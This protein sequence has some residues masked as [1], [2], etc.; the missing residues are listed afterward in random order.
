MHLYGGGNAFPLWEVLIKSNHTFAYG[1][2]VYASAGYARNAVTGDKAVL[3]VCASRTAF[4]VAGLV[5]LRTSTT[6]G[7]GTA[8][9]QRPKILI[10]P[11]LDGYLF[12]GQCSGTTTASIGLPYHLVDIEGAAANSTGTSNQ[13]INE[14]ATSNKNVYVVGFKG[15][16]SAP[17]AYAEVLFSWAKTKFSARGNTAQSNTLIGS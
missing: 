12:T 10:W 3:G 17:G 11:A 2:A 6:A 15:N 1:D 5:G 4:S 14:D 7:S 13:E 9:S 16:T 8:A